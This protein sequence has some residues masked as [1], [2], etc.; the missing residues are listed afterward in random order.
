MH[1]KESP[2]IPHMHLKNAI[3]YILDVMHEE[4]KTDHGRLVGG[5]CG[6]DHNEILS[7]FLETKREYGKPEGRQ[8][9]HFVI[10]FAKGETTEGTAYE[11]IRDFCEEYLGDRYDYVFAVHNDKA[12]LHGHIIFNSVS[13]TDGY[14]YHYKKGD[15]EKNIQPVTDRVC[16]AHQLQPLTFDEKRVGVSYASW[17]AKE[18]GKYNWSHIIA[19]DIDYVIGQS[20]TFEE[21]LKG[22]EQLSYRMRFG[23]SSSKGTDYITFSFIEPDG[24][25]HSRRSYK[26]PAGYSPG[27]IMRR[28]ATKEGSKRHE[29]FMEELAGRA[30]VYL[31]SDM[32]RSTQTYRR[33]Y[34]AVSYYK[35]PNPYAVPAYR[36]RRDMLR[37]DK[38]LEECRY[39]KEHEI[40]N[41]EG[42]VA[43]K[44]QLEQ[45]L[46]EL[47]L[48][49]KK[50]T[51]ILNAM[52]QEQ[53]ELLERYRS[54][55]D[56]ME[57]LEQEGNSGW[58]E[59]EEEL[60]QIEEQLPHELTKMKEGAAAY[61]DVKA[62]LKKEKRLL[63]RML[64]E[65]NQP[66][67][68]DDKVMPE[69]KL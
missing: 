15:W 16:V 56:S 60:V 69:R 1:M 42:I 62:M 19:A 4:E 10:S 33:L 21:F 28:I 11:V 38:L 5:N 3:D 32:T 7:C 67:A 66:A 46:K 64:R 54:L 31:K 14:K 9:Y 49:Q 59:Q 30:A 45:K 17:A 63:E 12:H 55:K 52:D 43:R 35:L 57:R 48:E 6:S 51:D 27:D 58:E 53:R 36:V 50:R 2:A 34:Q 22:M 23:H 44:K 39:L 13:R 18:K 40:K 8:G 47:A 41:R 37:L 61:E 68:M 65:E 20:S 26:L 29:A 25:K 24:T